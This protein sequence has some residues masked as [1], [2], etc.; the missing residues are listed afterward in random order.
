MRGVGS[1]GFELLYCGTKTSCNIAIK[2]HVPTEQCL[3]TC[4]YNKV[5]T[6]MDDLDK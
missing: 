3:A 1:V 4:R 6:F 2:F 5:V